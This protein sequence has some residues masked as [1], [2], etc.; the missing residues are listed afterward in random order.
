MRMEII[1]EKDYLIDIYVNGKAQS[2]KHR[3]QPTVVKKYIQTIDKLRVAKNTEELY[4]IRSLN[5]EKLI[6]DK[7]GLESVRVDKKYRI[8]FISTVEGKEP[9]TL[10]ICSIIELSNHYK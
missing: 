6:G 5:Y 8:E 1:F 9:D 2:K 4:P 7:H 3:F 10:T